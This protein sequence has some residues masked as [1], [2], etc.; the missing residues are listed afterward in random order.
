MTD[1]REELAV[2]LGN[3]CAAYQLP[4]APENQ[5]AL[6]QALADASL[7]IVARVR[8]EERE[9]CARVA[10][11][12]EDNSSKAD[13]PYDGGSGSMGYEKACWTIAAAIRALGDE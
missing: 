4:V 12:E 8:A 9:R 7:P 2:T 1:L 10:E 6:R 5:E 3:V 13:H 11:A